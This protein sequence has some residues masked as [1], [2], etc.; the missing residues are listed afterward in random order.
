MRDFQNNGSA[1]TSIWKGVAL[2]A[3]DLGARHFGT[4]EQKN[5]GR[6]ALGPWASGTRFI[7]FCTTHFDLF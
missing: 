3:R 5:I 4:R 7:K 1:K 2:G 6:R